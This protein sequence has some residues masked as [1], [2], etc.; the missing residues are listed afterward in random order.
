MLCGALL[1][2]QGEGGKECTTG[3]VCFKRRLL[4]MSDTLC[5]SLRSTEGVPGGPG[6]DHGQGVAAEAQR[7]GG[8]QQEA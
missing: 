2:E 5:S 1:E 7:E 4:R 8:Q 3:L 6:E